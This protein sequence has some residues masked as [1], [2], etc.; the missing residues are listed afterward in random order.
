MHNRNSKIYN[1]TD[2]KVH[3]KGQQCKELMNILLVLIALQMM[4]QHNKKQYYMNNKDLCK[5]I[6]H[7]VSICLSKLIVL[8]TPM[9]ENRCESEKIP[10][11]KQQQQ[12]HTHNDNKEFM[13]NVN[14]R[15]QT[16][17]QMCSS[18]HKCITSL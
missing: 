9:K 10:P 15:V 7:K 12:Q 1:N 17:M 16:T 6:K 3:F 8:Q 5:H 2:S 11:P 14:N 4:E 13:Y 18:H